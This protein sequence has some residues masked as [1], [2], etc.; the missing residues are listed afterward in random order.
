MKYLTNF[1]I[2]FFLTFSI[3]SE[4]AKDVI[5]KSEDLVRG[6]TSQ[7]II[8]MNIKKI[9]IDRTI[10][11]I[12]YDDRN[13]DAFFI[14]ILEPSKDK[15][16]SFLKVKNNLWQYLPSVG[17][18]IKIESSMM[19]DSWMGSDFTN[20]DLV[21]GASIVDNYEHSFLDS[22]NKEIYKI[23]MKAKPDSAVVWEKIIVEIYKKTYLPKIYYYYDHKNRLKKIMKFYDY[24]QI[25][26]RTNL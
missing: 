3:Y 16:I 24:K 7:A 19:A 4:S 2:L 20:E 5:K 10:K 14:K 17:K 15:G 25:Q 6:K 13:K 22:S 11:F 21:K 12:A 8:K 18:I 26:N 1:F 23:E 9:R